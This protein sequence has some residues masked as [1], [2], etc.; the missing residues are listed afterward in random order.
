MASSPV[1]ERLH[2]RIVN[3]WCMYDWANSAFATTIMAALLP[4]YFYNVAAAGLPEARASAIWSY[5]VA[6]SMLVV[7]LMGPVLGAIADYTASKKR[8]MRAFLAV[9]VLFTSLL[10]LVQ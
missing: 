4:P 9:A 2:R 3:A 1:A 5:S 10:F 6:A 8:F 7:A